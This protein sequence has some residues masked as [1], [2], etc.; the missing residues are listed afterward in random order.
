MFPMMASGS[1]LRPDPSRRPSRVSFL[2]ASAA[3]VV[4]AAGCASIPATRTHPELPQRKAGIRTVGILPPVIKM[5]QERAQFG[6]NKVVPNDA[7]SSVA[8]EAVSRAFTEEM[9]ADGITVLPVGTDD[10]EV[11]ELSDLY[12][13]VEFSIRVHSWENQAGSFLPQEPFPE[14]VRALDYAVGPAGEVMERHH[15]DAFGMVRGFNLLPTAGA[16]AKDGAEIALA[17]LA[18]IGG[19]PV[20]VMTL[21]KIELRVV[22]IDRAG[23]VLY[24]GVADDHTAAPSDEGESGGGSPPPVDLRDAR[25][26]RRY[27]RAALAKYRA[28]A[29]R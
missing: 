3:L 10:S 1:R 6:L 24:Y 9:A 19:V 11:S 20:P 23:S 18:A 17:V 21:K 8:G 14:K 26:A 4:A 5:A 2:A 15:V 12:N 13:A 29:S 7:W 27:V 25:A 22:L 16:S 28:G